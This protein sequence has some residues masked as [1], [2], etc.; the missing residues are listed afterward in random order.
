MHTLQTFSATRG[1]GATLILVLLILLGFCFCL[2]L[3]LGS[4]PL[5]ARTLLA[6]ITGKD[7]S[8]QAYRIVRYV[9]LTRTLA[10]LLSGMAL[11]L[12][13][14]LL[15]KSLHNPLAGP[16]IIGVN[17]GSGLLTLLA[18]AFFPRMLA[19]GAFASF[20]GALMATLLVYALARRSGST[21]LT[22]IL[23]GVAVSSLLGSCTDALLTL[24]PE[25]QLGRIDFLIGSFA[26]VTF[27]QLQLAA[28]LI[29][30]GITCSLFLG[31]PLAI[32]SLGDEVARSLGLD[33]RRTRFLSLML[34][35]LLSATVVSMCGL[36][37]FVGLVVPH[38]VRFLI[39]EESP[40]YLLSCTLGGAIMTVGCDLVARMLFSPYELPTGVVLSFLGSPFFLLLLFTRKRRTANA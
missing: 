37:G 6:I 38:M 10:S 29:L 32:L 11:A 13:G 31:K 35:A 9:R 22:I 12:S 4:T 36:V 40:L 26:H 23:A 15:Q 27:S 21:R 18:A 33:V 5:G 24:R 20:L 34:S 1:R 14:S 2:S 25:T 17:A 19:L 30:L 16:S 7:T 3:C 8:S 28:P 39:G